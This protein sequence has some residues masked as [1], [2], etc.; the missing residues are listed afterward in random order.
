MTDYNYSRKRMYRYALV[1]IFSAIAFVLS[2][3]P[4]FT[5][6]QPLDVDFSDAPAVAMSLM[7]GP[8]YGLAVTVI[9]SVIH[10]SAS[11]TGYVGLLANIIMGGVFSVC[12]GLFKSIFSHKISGVPLAI[13]SA[14]LAIIPQIIFAIPTNFYI[15]FPFYGV[16]L[17][18]A[19][20][21]AQAATLIIAAHNAIKDALA[22]AAASLIIYPVFLKV[23]E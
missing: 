19:Y 6:F 16:S 21:T 17:A 2:L 5:V 11:S 15:L 14:S 12:A 1:G 3:F 9:K 23:K 22:V 4:K 18:D 13:L 10:L 7:Y 8:L 20:G